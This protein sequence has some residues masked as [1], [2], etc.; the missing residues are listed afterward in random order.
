M[1]VVETKLGFLQVQG[2]GVLGHAVKLR[3]ATLG[4]APE[5]FNTVD[6]IG[7]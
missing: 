3:Q 4:E 7:P 6:V 1:P 2:K 5:R